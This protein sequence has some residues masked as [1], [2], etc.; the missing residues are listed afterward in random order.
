MVDEEDE[1]ESDNSELSSE[2][3]CRL[4]FDLLRLDLDGDLASF[5]FFLYFLVL[6]DDGDVLLLCFFFFFLSSM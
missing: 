6:L 2:D 4:C 1:L 5:F 3:L